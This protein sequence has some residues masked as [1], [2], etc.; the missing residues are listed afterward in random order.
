MTK[1]VTVSLPDDVGAALEGLPAGQ[2]SA[3]VVLALRRLDESD[4]VRALLQQS[5]FP[6]F[7]VDPVGAHQRAGGTAVGDDAYQAAVARVAELTGT[8]AEELA[9]RLADGKQVAA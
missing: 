4:Q 8:T 6:L 3:R 2:R 9:T 7:P 5:G 1:K